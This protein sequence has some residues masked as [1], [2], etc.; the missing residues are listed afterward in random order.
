MVTIFTSFSGQG[1]VEKMIVNFCRGCI[2]KQRRVKLLLV[3]NTSRHLTN[4]PREVEVIKLDAN[5]NL[6]ALFPLVT[7]LKKC[8]PKSMLVAKDRSARVAV[9]AKY[10]SGVSTKLWLRIGTTTSATKKY[11][12]GWLRNWGIKWTYQRCEGIIAV[13]NG[14]KEDVI[15]RSH[16]DSKKVKVIANPVIS[17]DIY[18][19]A[20]ITPSHRFI[21]K[22]DRPLIVGMGRISFEKDFATLINAVSIVNKTMEVNLLIIGDGTNNHLTK[23]KPK[24][25]SFLGYTPNPYQYLSRADV[26][27][28][29]SRWEGSPNSLTEALSLGTQV[30]S[31]DCPSGPN[32]ILNNGSVAP[33]VAVGDSKQMASAIIDVL[34]TPR[35]I[36][37]LKAATLNY[38]IEQSTDH[39]LNLLDN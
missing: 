26:F 21:T 39:Y 34:K 10:L 24:W 28:L 32:E 22:K 27:V 4:L 1:G 25:L 15:A 37:R 5:H 2:K 20:Q 8:K 7:Y 30:V 9:L 31:T 29:S 13:S 38:T 18:T 36:D 23:N 17:N 6:T 12:R 16:I 33:L 11:K 35:P 3:K 19:M 14:V